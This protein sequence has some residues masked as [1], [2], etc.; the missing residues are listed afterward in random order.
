MDYKLANALELIE[1]TS[2][3]STLKLPFE[4]WVISSDLEGKTLLSSKS[5]TDSFLSAITLTFLIIKKTKI[6]NT[7]TFTF[8]SKQ[9]ACDSLLGRGVLE[10]LEHAQLWFWNKLFSILSKR[11]ED[12]IQTT[13]PP[14]FLC[15][16]AYYPYMK[17]ST[18]VASYKWVATS[19]AV[20][21]T[22]LTK[23]LYTLLL[24]QSPQFNLFASHSNSF[25]SC[26]HTNH[27]S[28]PSLVFPTF[29]YHYINSHIFSP[30]DC[31]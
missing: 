25:P 10:F 11:E 19:G 14:F 1:T 21:Q 8:P 6:L 2:P 20:C 30:P 5:T 16:N 18:N 4:L 26:S 17:F 9:V 22:G 3:I 15:P 28:T 24:N 23:T 31:F 13:H 29:S 27:S 7:I 12:Q